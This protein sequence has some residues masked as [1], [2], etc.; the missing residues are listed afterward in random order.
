MCQILSKLITLEIAQNK[1]VIET[2]KK[3]QVFGFIKEEQTLFFFYFNDKSILICTSNNLTYKTKLFVHYNQVQLYVD[4]IPNI[5]TFEDT[6]KINNGQIKDK[7]E[8]MYIL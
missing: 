7:F 2:N 8:F 3:F 1:L 4:V 6:A 5:R